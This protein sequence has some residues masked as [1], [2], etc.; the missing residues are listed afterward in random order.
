[1]T[2]FAVIFS[3]ISFVFSL[4]MFGSDH[5]WRCSPVSLKPDLGELI[6]I[7]LKSKVDS[8]TKR[9]KK[10]ILKFIEYCN[11]SGVQP[12]PPFPVAFI[13]AY[14]FSVYKSSSSYASLV[15]THAALKWFHSFG[16]SNGANP[17]DISICHNLLE[18]A[19]P[20]K[21]V[22]VKR[23]PISAEIIK[24]IIDK[25]AGLSANLKDIRVA[26]ICSL[27]FAGFFRYNELGNIA[28]VHLEFFPDY[29]RVFVPRAKNDIY[30]EGNYV[31]I[32]R[33]NSQYCPVALLERYIFMGN[34]D[35][36]SSVVLF[37]P[38]RFFK[39]T[40]SYKLYGVK[41][42][43][44][45]CRE[46]FKECLK[47]VGV[48]HKLYGLHSLRSGGATSAVSYNPSLSERVLKLHGRWKSDTAKDMYIL[49]DVSKRLQVT[50]QLGL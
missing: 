1:M 27:G 20:D 19:E 30:R 32:K 38:V 3:V 36:S 24:S 34:I 47:E 10:E 2:V 13:V 14:L 9:Y 6:S 37:R 7:L 46:I 48:N 40:N 17:L 25:F 29:L 35:L 41:L 15:M 12:V 28:P 11:F 44:T 16:L 43:Y 5:C 42:S 49:E 26:C 50:S 45:R 8:T 21:P 31:Y 4:Q 18:A 39:S 33:L 22:S 23:A